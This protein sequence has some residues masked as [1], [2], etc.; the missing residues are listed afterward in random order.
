MRVKKRLAKDLFVEATL[1]MHIF[2]FDVYYCT[3]IECSMCTYMYIPALFGVFFKLFYIPSHYT[4]IRNL[5][6]CL[7][8]RNRDIYGKIFGILHPQYIQQN[9][10]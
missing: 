3:L 10:T 8:S 6:L 9:Y 1:H 4:Y 7:L 2:S 5:H